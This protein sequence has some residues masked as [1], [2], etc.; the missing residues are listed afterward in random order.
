[1][2]LHSEGSS[3]MEE[4]EARGGKEERGLDGWA[5]AQAEFQKRY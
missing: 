5:V 1:M 2:R 3:S 4:R